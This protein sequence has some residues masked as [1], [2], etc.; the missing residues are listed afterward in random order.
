M[1]DTVI[2]F[3]Q[4]LGVI[5]FAASG[6]MTAIEKKMDIFGVSIIGIVTAIGGGVIRDV[7]LGI[8]PPYIF[9]D[10]VFPI[11]ALATS[12]IVFSKPVRS[13][14][15][16]EKAVYDRILLWFDSI[17]LGIFVVCGIESAYALS[18][19]FTVFL[20]V[21]VG[22]ISGTG[23]SILRDVLTS[24][25][26]AIFVKHFYACAAMIGSFVTCGLWN[27]AGDLVSMLAGTV[28]II[29]LRL[30][31]AKYHWELAKA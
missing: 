23:G 25:T 11:V 17:G 10:P 29:I 31:A 24:Q 16:K 12:L 8:T 21:F 7:I 5:A 15:K 9:V 1:T 26:P 20:L 18:S 30:L 2:Y 14:L 22:M 6:A 13:Y 19:D 28:V 4:I 3:I 27:I